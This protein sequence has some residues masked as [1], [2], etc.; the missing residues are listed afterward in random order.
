VYL[1]PTA[2]LSLLPIIKYH[3]FQDENGAAAIS[4]KENQFSVK[5][6]EYSGHRK[7]S[8]MAEKEGTEVSNSP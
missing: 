8:D 7:T 3:G 5:V 4:E 6:K 1:K 2:F